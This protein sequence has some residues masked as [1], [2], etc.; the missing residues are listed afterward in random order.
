[1]LE[2]GQD[3]ARYHAELASTIGSEGIDLV[4]CAGPL[5]SHLYE[6]IPAHK[7]GAMASSSQEL[8]QPLLSALRA[9]DAVMIKGSLGSR[10]GPLAEALRSELS[11]PPKREEHG[12]AA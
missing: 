12:H 5:M 3:A 4:F 1:M 7:R 8:R 2:L 11:T 6:H 10:M 9:G